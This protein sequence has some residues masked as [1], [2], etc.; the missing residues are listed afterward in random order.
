MSNPTF[1]HCV[2]NPWTVDG[3]KRV[4]AEE[5][6]YL[7]IKSLHK[8]SMAWLL[9]VKLCELTGIADPIAEWKARDNGKTPKITERQRVL[10]NV[11]VFEDFAGPMTCPKTKET[12]C[13]N[14]N[15]HIWPPGWP[16]MSDGDDWGIRD[17]EMA[18]ARKRLF[19]VIDQT[20][21]LDWLLITSNPENAP[22][23]IPQYGF[24][25]A[26][27]PGTLGRYCLSDNVWIG[28]RVSSQSDVDKQ[29]QSLL[30]I[31]PRVRFLVVD[32]M[33]EPIY[34]KKWFTRFRCYVCKH[35]TAR[36]V[37][38][39]TCPDCGQTALGSQHFSPAVD[40]VICG[41]ETGP[42]AR[43]LRLDWVRNLRD[44]C[45]MAGVPFWLERLGSNPTIIVRSASQMSSEALE[46]GASGE[47][48][49]FKINHADGADPDGWPTD[50]RVRE[51]PK[52][53]T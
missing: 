25:N 22:E 35:E 30:K 41:G 7:P 38:G 6:R 23:M 11:D 24:P 16:S 40:W 33:I 46:C 13:I 51:L 15:G 4:V 18:D 32:P 31:S 5:K 9:H 36:K 27:I 21:H 53:G 50:L 39:F 3:D 52:G 19:S 44:Q 2:F 29:I 49:S 26:G 10:V 34:L 42:N 20:P 14:A 48:V 37:D 43:P 8:K 45:Q 47:L 28:A 12:L 17:Y 1:A